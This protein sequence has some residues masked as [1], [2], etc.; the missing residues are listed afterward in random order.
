MLVMALLLGCKSEKKE[1]KM[2]TTE[3]IEETITVTPV[4][5]AMMESAII[6]EAN[7]RQYSPQG[8]FTEFT[9]DIPELKN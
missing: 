5:G 7:I 8:T 6:Y 2:S 4:S 1:E 3:I 9:K